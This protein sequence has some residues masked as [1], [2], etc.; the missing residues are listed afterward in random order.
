MNTDNRYSVVKDIYAAKRIEEFHQ[1]FDYIPKTVVAEDIGTSAKR[2]T[3]LI[4]EPH[5]FTGE[6]IYQMS[7]LFG[8]PLDKF[9]MLLMKNFIEKMKH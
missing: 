2:I 7:Q 9:F 4:E 5:T 1:I 3:R 6:E 8:I